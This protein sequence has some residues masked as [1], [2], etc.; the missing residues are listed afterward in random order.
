MIVLLGRGSLTFLREK[1][2]RTKYNAQ[3]TKWKEKGGEKRAGKAKIL[4]V[5]F[6][7]CDAPNW[8][9]YF[10]PS[11][12][13]FLSSLF[14]LS[15]TAPHILHHTTQR[16]Y[17]P[18]IRA[19]SWSKEDWREFWRPLDLFLLKYLA[20]D[21]GTSWLFFFFQIDVVF[22]LQYLVAL[23]KEWDWRKLLFAKGCFKWAK[24]KI[25]C[26]AASFFNS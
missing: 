26:A 16:N 4:R 25:D 14:S 22:F 18:G 7:S 10:F 8:M 20:L 9:S 17:Q 11:S 24:K 13:S 15:H 3:K 23:F 1:K 19:R 21:P 12:L 2:H 6:S 5:H